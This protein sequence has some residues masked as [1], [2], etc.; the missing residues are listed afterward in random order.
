MNFLGWTITICRRAAREL[1][2][3]RN[4]AAMTNC[5]GTAA[6]ASGDVVTARIH[7]DE[8]L[9]AEHL[10]R[11]AADQQWLRQ[12]RGQTVH[13]YEPDQF[14]ATLRLRLGAAAAV[15][16][17]AQFAAIL[18]EEIALLG[19]AIYDITG[20]MFLEDLVLEGRMLLADLHL[21]LGHAMAMAEFGAGRS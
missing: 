19:Q 14:A 5:V 11:S 17:D 9:L 13:L 20:D 4:A 21:R 6:I 16:V 18:P 12:R 10:L 7:R 8:I 15:E 2:A 3:D 1:P